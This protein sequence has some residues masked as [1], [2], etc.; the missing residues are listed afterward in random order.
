LLRILLVDDNAMAR[1]AIKAALQRHSEWVVVGEACNGQEAL[2][3]FP[4]YRPQLTVMDFLMPEMN[5]L[6]AAHHLKERNPDALILMITTDPSIQLQQE[7][8]RAGISGVC[9]KDEMD[10]LENAVD[11]VIHGGTFFGEEAVA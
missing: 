1:A 3:T 4:R 9:A 5:G 8:R 2:E 10:C 7:A 6:E 11:A